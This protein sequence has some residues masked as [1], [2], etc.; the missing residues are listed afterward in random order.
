M[1]R[2]SPWL[3]NLS[4]IEMSLYSLGLASLIEMLMLGTFKEEQLV[5]VKQNLEKQALDYRKYYTMWSQQIEKLANEGVERNILKE[6]GDAGKALGGF[7]GGIPL[8]K[9]GP[10][11]EWLQGGGTMLS[12]NANN[13]A[14]D[15]VKSLASVSDPGLSIFTERIDELNCIYNH[16]S[17]I[18]FDKEHIYLVSG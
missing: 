16:T 15:A 2:R 11:D 17:E 5:D 7:I 1:L 13:M 12:K 18:C 3:R 9:E 14:M 6:I 10:V 4:T 8:V